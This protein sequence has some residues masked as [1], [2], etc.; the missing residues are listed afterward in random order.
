ML[1]HKLKSFH[2]ILELMLAIEIETVVD[3]LFSFWCPRLLSKVGRH[4]ESLQE[5][6][7]SCHI[8]FKNDGRRVRAPAGA[9]TPE[10]R[11]FCFLKRKRVRGHIRRWWL[12]CKFRLSACARCVY[13]ALVGPL[14]NADFKNWSDAFTKSGM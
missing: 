10:R 7:S 6:S 1:F 8:S 13:T 3:L 2:V 4:L 9:E 11:R 12:G 14:L 5:R